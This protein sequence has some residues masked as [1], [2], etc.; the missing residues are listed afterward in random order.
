MANL[1]LTG[2]IDA[3]VDGHAD[4]T[5]ISD[6]TAALS[7]AVALCFGR[8]TMA[9]LDA[10]LP[11]STQVRAPSSWL[12][13]PP[14]RYRLQSSLVLRSM[15]G[16]VVRGGGSVMTQL[17][18][19]GGTAA[20]PLLAALELDGI[21]DSTFSDLSV[22]VDG[23]GDVR[24]L[25]Y[26]HWNPD[27]AYRSTTRNV[28][29]NVQAGPVNGFFR[30]SAWQLGTLPGDGRTGLQCDQ[31]ELFNVGASGQYDTVRGDRT[32]VDGVM[33]KDLYFQRG[34]RFG[35][36]KYGN[37]GWHQAHGLYSHH[38]RYGVDW[39][40][41]EC[42]IYGGLIQSN[43]VDLYASSPP[44]SYI[45][46]KNLRSEDSGRF[47]A[48]AGGGGNTNAFHASLEDCHW[49]LPGG[50][51]VLL[52]GITSAGSNTLEDA[53][54]NWA[55]NTWVGYIARVT[56][57]A[58]DGQERRIIANTGNRLTLASNWTTIP[59]APSIYVITPAATGGSTTSLEKTGANWPTNEWRG[60][61]VYLLSGPAK[62]CVGWVDSNTDQALVIDNTHAP[63]PKPPDWTIAP[64]PDTAFALAKIPPDGEFIQWNFAGVFR[65]S[66]LAARDAIY[67]ALGIRHRI[68]IH[69]SVRQCTALIDGASIG[70]TTRAQAFSGAPGLAA[71]EVRGWESVDISGQ[72]ENAS[73]AGQILIHGG[74]AVDLTTITTSTTL[75]KLHDHIRVDA[76]AGVVTVTLPDAKRFVGRRFVV[77]KIDP[78]TNA[79]R[80]CGQAGQTIDDVASR[81]TVKRWAK[82]R[83]YSTGDNWETD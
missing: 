23:G 35:D 67:T 13:I 7:N 17:W 49:T 32:A 75:D 76:A 16:L 6:S 43:D 46:A 8:A 21:A 31:T 39:W 52:S 57:G 36:G 5:G 79:V 10:A 56:K 42:P 20:H 3:V 11:P 68:G 15:E 47:F 1:T 66:G 48:T 41:A 77:K 62:G 40:A 51:N 80:V 61:Y 54:Q 55:A 37:N 73:E 58:G 64:D 45:T 44:A 18:C 78:S 4:S 59:T 34:F 72:D 60:L 29:V 2:M 82:F 70:E 38:C 33:R 24:V 50:N 30:E 26:L 25:V 22:G 65:V 63:D 28:F 14:G 27:R 83:L 81:S 19:Y 53:T 12:Y 69:P 9:E 71:I 74:H